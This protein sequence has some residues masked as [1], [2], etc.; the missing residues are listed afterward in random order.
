MKRILREPLLHFFLIGF[1]LFVVY[2]LVNRSNA[3]D[4]DNTIVVSSGR[5]EQLATVFGKTWQRP[6]TAVEL[7]GLIDDFVLEEIYFRQAVAM[8]MDRDDTIIRRRLRQKLEFLTDDTSALV[9][10]SE[11]EL[12]EYLAANE[13]KFRQ[14]PT[15]SFDQ[16]YFNPEKHGDDPESEVSEMLSLIRTGKDV[17]DASL[18]PS[19]YDLVERNAVDGTFGTGFSSHLDDLEIGEWQGPIRSGLGIHL[20][21]LKARTEGRLPELSQIREI[22]ER[23]WRNEQ[24]VS[25]RKKMNDRLL[26]DYEVE[27]QWPDD[28]SDQP[29]PKRQTQQK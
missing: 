22:V 14:S 7:K 24:R 1:G 16:V 21:R 28:F 9:D 17:G 11:K 18:L 5:V 15:Y 4:S 12:A 6:P 8:Q 23:E 3:A 20:V 10:P 13:Q 27:I 2:G 26:Q 19:S 25:T 29:S